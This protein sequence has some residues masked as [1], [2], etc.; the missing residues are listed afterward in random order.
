MP[1]KIN[2]S[3]SG[4]VTLAAPATGSDVTVTL[5]SAA[6]T[7]QTV[8]GAWTSFTPTIGAYTG[9]LTAS[10]V[11]SA[12]YQQIGKLVIA[13][14]DISFT[15]GSATVGLTFTLPVNANATYGVYFGGVEVLISG[16][17]VKGYNDSATRIFINKYDNGVPWSTGNTSSSHRICGVA[18]Y[19]AA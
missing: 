4:S 9:S 5:P 15:P 18:T 6:G 1:I 7:V 11:Q 16:F 8:P 17:S 2:G 12:A 3:T 10:T 19:E 13:R 14:Y